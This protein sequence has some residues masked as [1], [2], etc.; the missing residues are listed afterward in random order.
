MR[1][2][3]ERYAPVLRF[4]SQERF[5]PVAV[6]DYLNQKECRLFHNK[7]LFDRD[8]TSEWDAFGNDKGSRADALG[9]FN[10][11]QYYLQFT[12]RTFGTGCLITYL[13]AL[14]G[15]V[16]LL[17]YF[18]GSRWALWA[19][20]IGIGL[21]ALSRLLRSQAG[22]GLVAALLLSVICGIPFWIVSVRA[23][24]GQLPWILASIILF[25]FIL[26]FVASAIRSTPGLIMD[27]FSRATDETADNAYRQTMDIDKYACY[28]RITHHNQWTLLNYVYFYAFND[29]RKAAEGINHHEGD[30]EAV[31]IFLKGDSPIPYGVALSQH[32]DGVFQRWDAM[33]KVKDENG[34][35][36]L[37]PIIYVALGSHANYAAPSVIRAPE[38]FKKGVVQT[39]I[40]GI[41]LFIRRLTDKG[42]ATEIVDGKGTRLHV[43]NAQEIQLA[44]GQPA[45]DADHKTGYQKDYEQ[46][47]LSQLKN[48]DLS[49]LSNRM[50]DLVRGSEPEPGKAQ[51]L[52]H[53]ITPQPVR[54]KLEELEPAAA[55]RQIQ[56]AS[57]ELIVLDPLPGWINFRGLWGVKSWLKDESG[58]PGPK[59]DRPEPGAQ[60]PRLRWQWPIEW[61]AKLEGHN[62]S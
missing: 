54:K 12:K 50:Q 3:L 2:E 52:I 42:L 46:A 31:T 28:G 9:E 4:S 40:Y 45:A 53:K 47:L 5:F 13:I 30:W 39:I 56:D 44:A 25:I 32:H 49:I 36:T 18:S 41:D 7:V 57:M 14:A 24:S 62:K 37:H 11:S 22:T 15:V 51:Q 23:A 58:P 48:E 17:F 19:L 1:R 6:E 16:F 60:F 21:L 38:L 29:W 43:S 20:G 61:L 59:W 27:F 26:V 35:E 33:H 10:G 34:Q 55:S 8:V